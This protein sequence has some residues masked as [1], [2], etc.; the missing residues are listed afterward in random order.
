[1]T[2]VGVFGRSWWCR[3]GGAA[4]L[5]LLATVVWFRDPRD[6]IFWA[7]VAFFAAHVVQTTRR[8][9]WHRRHRTVATVTR[10]HRTQPAP[11]PFPTTFLPPPATSLIRL[12]IP[13]K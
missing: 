8:Y 12:D 2:E 13:L 3:G 4:T 1:M 5:L 6:L 10:H 11:A 7:A 9:L